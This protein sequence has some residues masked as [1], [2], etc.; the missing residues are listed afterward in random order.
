M[1][2]NTV[3]AG[4]FDA[5]TGCR[6]WSDTALTSSGGASGVHGPDTSAGY[7]AFID[8]GA[9]ALQGNGSRQIGMAL[10]SIYLRASDWTEGTNGTLEVRLAFSQDGSAVDATSVVKGYDGAAPTAWEERIPFTN[11]HMGTT[12]RYVQVQLRVAG[13][14]AQVDAGWHVTADSRLT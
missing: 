1:A 7:P 9:G 2:Q 3:Q 4:I 14:G 11:E 13:T 12:Y 6:D 8:F 5:S 10:A